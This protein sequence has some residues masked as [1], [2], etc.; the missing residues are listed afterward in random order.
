MRAR[1][2]DRFAELHHEREQAQAQLDIF[3]AATPKA[4]EPALLDELPSPKTSC[5]TRKPACSTRSTCR[6]YGTSP[7]AKPPLRRDHRDHPAPPPGLLDPGHDGYDDTADIPAEQAAN[8]E[9]LFESPIGDLI[10]STPPTGSARRLKVE[11]AFSL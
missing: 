11:A 8:V 9:D 6:S 4:A 1:I 10:K 5:P 3:Q 7:A 2:P